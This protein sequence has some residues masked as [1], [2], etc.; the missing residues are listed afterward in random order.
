MPWMDGPEG[1]I[2]FEASE[3]VGVGSETL[4]VRIASLDHIIA[5]KET[6]N[7]PKDLDALKEL[8]RVRDRQDRQRKATGPS[9][10]DDGT[11]GVGL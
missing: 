2:T 8:R 7:R 9:L 4:I 10:V 5:A 3:E 1:R 11:P 6:A